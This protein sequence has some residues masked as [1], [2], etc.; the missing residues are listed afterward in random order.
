M[1]SNFTLRI[2]AEKE[3]CYA[4]SEPTVLKCGRFGECSESSL[5]I[6]RLAVILKRALSLWRGEPEIEVPKSDLETL[7]S[8]GN[9][10][11]TL[12]LMH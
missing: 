7:L 1:Y 6:V 4:T 12:S 8:Q 11:E 5:G 2:P 9:A 3:S 10:L